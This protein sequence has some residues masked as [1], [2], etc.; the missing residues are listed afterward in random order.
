MY[1]DQGPS[2]SPEELPTIDKGI[3]PDCRFPR[4]NFAWCQYC[5]SQYFE[6]NSSWDSGSIQLNRLIKET[7]LGARQCGDYLLFIEFLDFSLIQEEAR[8]GFSTVYSAIW[9]EGP[10]ELWD[11]G[12]QEW[13]RNGP[14]KVA[15]K[16][17]DN[18]QKLTDYFIQQVKLHYKALQ[19]HSVADTIGFTRDPT[20]AYMVVMRYYQ[21]GDL[22]KYLEAIKGDLNWKEKIDMLWGIAGGLDDVH[23]R[24]LVHK[25]LHGGNLLVEDESI[26]TDARIADLGLCGPVDKIADDHIYGVLPYIAPEGMPAVYETLMKRCWNADLEVRPS[27]AELNEILGQWICDLCDNPSPNEISSQFTKAEDDLTDAW[28]ADAYPLNQYQRAYY[29]SRI[30]PFSPSDVSKNWNYA[31]LNETGI[32]K[33]MVVMDGMSH[34]ND[35]HASQRG[36]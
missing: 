32:S 4:T 3:C 7:Q 29:Y 36:E 5:E 22:H 9:L 31:K 14:M 18:S 33:D 24:N 21:N 2:T 6:E 13:L 11:E 19:S 27:A 15:L 23:K 28:S 8:G 12:S 20:G 16:R 26:S 1:S 25:D 35:K 30:L 34:I 17:L 10:R